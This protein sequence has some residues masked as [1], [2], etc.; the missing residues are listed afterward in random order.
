MFIKWQWT[1]LSTSQLSFI[2]FHHLFIEDISTAVCHLLYYTVVAIN[3]YG[4]LVKCYRQG[5]LQPWQQHLSQCPR[6]Y[7]NSHM[8]SNPVLCGERWQLKAGTVTWHLMQFTHVF[9]CLSIN[10]NAQLY[11]NGSLMFAFVDTSIRMSYYL[12]IC[13]CSQTLMWDLK[14]RS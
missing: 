1:N 6:I 10:F 9:W 3:K 14:L 12:A 8:I 2:H 13:Q 4:E 5:K 7:Y 11:L